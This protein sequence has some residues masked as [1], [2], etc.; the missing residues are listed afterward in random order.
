MNC[1]TCQSLISAV[2]DERLDGHRLTAFHAHVA[3]CASCASEVAVIDRASAALR[4]F[5]PAEPRAGLAARLAKVAVGTTVSPPSFLQ[6]WLGVAQPAA[7]M[8]VAIAAVV[9]VTLMRGVATQPRSVDGHGSD[10]I[11]VETGGE[12][13]DEIALAVLA[14]DEEEL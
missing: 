10:P 9:S 6:R 13:G 14:M 5:G 12:N 1:R 4:A 2:I 11:A 8:A 3:N 7:L